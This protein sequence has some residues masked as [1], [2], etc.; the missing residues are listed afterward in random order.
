MYMIASFDCKF[1][2]NQEK[3]ERILQHFG[4]RKI[5]SSLYVGELENNERE[6]MAESIDEIIRENDSLLI[7]PICKNCYLKKDCCGREI[8]VNYQTFIIDD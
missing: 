6:M 2:S 1:K 7:I 5:Q 4:L 8:I 3:I